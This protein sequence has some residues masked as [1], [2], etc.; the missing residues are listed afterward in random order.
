MLIQHTYSVTYNSCI[1]IH[2]LLRILLRIAK[3]RSSVGCVVCFNSE[4]L[5]RQLL[6]LSKLETSITDNGVE[7][8]II[9]QHPVALVFN[10]KHI[11]LPSQVQLLY[12]YL[13]VYIDLIL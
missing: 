8:N 4:M 3:T 2:S 9:F 11:R 12:S 13:Y 7:N 5:R 1:L 10:Y 6:G